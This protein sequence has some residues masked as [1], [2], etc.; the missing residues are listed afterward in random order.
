MIL[1]GSN[2]LSVCYTNRDSRILCAH[3]FN[4]IAGHRS[5]RYQSDS[6][7]LRDSVR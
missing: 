3:S 6:I 2:P 1:A 4:V 5:G 7:V